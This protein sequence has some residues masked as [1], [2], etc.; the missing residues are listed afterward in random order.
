MRLRDWAFHPIITWRV[1]K[2][3]KKAFEKHLEEIKGFFP[4]TEEEQLPEWCK[5]LMQGLD[6]SVNIAACKYTGRIPDIKKVSYLIDRFTEDLSSLDRQR[7]F[8]DRYIIWLQKRKNKLV[9]EATEE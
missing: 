9:R 2:V 5:P 1:R 6:T 4:K 3:F 7:E 8:L